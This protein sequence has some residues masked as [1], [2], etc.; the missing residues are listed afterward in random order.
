MQNQEATNEPE[1][2]SKL[3]RVRTSFFTIGTIIGIILLLMGV[4]YALGKISLAVSIV[5]FAMVIVF[6]LRSPVAFFERKG[7]KRVFGTLLAYL[8]ALAIIVILVV[9][10]GP[11][12]GEQ[13]DALL[14]ALPSYATQVV[15]WV[16]DL[17]V[18]YGYLLGGDMAQSFAKDFGATLSEW[19]SSIASASASGL[20]SLGTSIT[21]TFIVTLM[22]IVTAFWVLK[23]LPQMKKEIRILV[24]PK[25]REDASVVSA[26]CA[27]VADGYIKGVLISS[28]C[29][30][31][32][33]GIG[34]AIVGVPYPA[35]LGLLTG[36]L[37]II[38]ILGPWIGGAFAALMGLFVSPVACLLAII[39]T[40]GAQQFTDT[41]IQPRIMSSTV[42]L[43]PALVI[44]ALTAGG[45]L[46]GIVGMIVAVPVL[47]AVKAVFV[48]YFEKRTGRKLVH[49]D[50]ALFAGCSK[51]GT[52]PDPALDAT[53]S[54]EC[55]RTH[56][57]NRKVKDRLAKQLRRDDSKADATS[58]AAPS[59]REAGN[60]AEIIESED[61]RES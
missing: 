38:P 18:T 24:S 3:D 43:H 11:L 31:L 6:I 49:E 7:I 58:D 51:G 16:E 5:F 35:V 20:I 21:N 61:T 37:N 45:N 22:S 15:D 60:E 53:F 52:D 10:I 26:L 39:I 1:Q 9:I 50:G 48:Y 23:D 44:L 25:F 57:K 42:E 32:I 8:I 33:A 47:A 29:T 27:H 40:V 30:G 14:E 4:G 2:L 34:Y 55:E 54:S 28:T 12:F 56:I 17:W 19:T 36:I 13:I 41:F 59:A 46:G